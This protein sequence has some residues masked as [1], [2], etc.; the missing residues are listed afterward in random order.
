MTRQILEKIHEQAQAVYVAAIEA[1]MSDARQGFMRG[2]FF[3][4]GELCVQQV[5]FAAMENLSLIEK[6]LELADIQ[7]AMEQRGATFH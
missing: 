3:G 6:L 5:V 1:G 7:E 4:G 2:S